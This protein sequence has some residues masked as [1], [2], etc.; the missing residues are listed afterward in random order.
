MADNSDIPA[1]LLSRMS[2]S[3]IMQFRQALAASQGGGGLAPQADAQRNAIAQ[4]MMPQQAL[5]GGTVQYST[6]T[7]PTG[8][9]PQ[10][11]NADIP[12]ELLARMSPTD[13]MLF[14]R[15]SA[16]QAIPTGVAGPYG[17]GAMGQPQV[18][19]GY[20][21]FSG[22]GL[23]GYAGGTGLTPPGAGDT[24]A[25]GGGAPPPPPPPPADFNS[26]FGNW[27]LV[28][29]PGYFDSTFRSIPGQPYGPGYFDN[30]F[31]SV[32]PGS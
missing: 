27:G 11:G 17:G 25:G 15:A 12:P 14:R 4:Q 2:P 31:G 21:A 10:P 20:N 29:P 23:P 3:D 28:A 24:F 19:S 32:S 7:A 22:A 6:P 16:G 8:V 1:N 26:R 5:S 30:T 13:I 9:A 18:P